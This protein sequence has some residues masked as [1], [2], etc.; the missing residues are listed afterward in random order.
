MECEFEIDIKE[1]DA[2]GM[3]FKPYIKFRILQ[4]NMTPKCMTEGEI[5]YQANALIKQVEKLRKEARK[6]LKAAQSR[7]DKIVVDRRKK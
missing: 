2:S 4:L 7:H 6:K 5:D 1:P 3:L